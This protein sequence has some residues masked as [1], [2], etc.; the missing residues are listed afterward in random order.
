MLSSCF[1]YFRWACFNYSCCFLVL[2]LKSS[3]ADEDDDLRSHEGSGDETESEEEEDDAEHGDEY[4]EGESVQED[5]HEQEEEVRQEHEQ[6]H[7]E[8]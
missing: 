8:F 2:I 6:T 7:S 1:Y 3:R 5:E 4:E